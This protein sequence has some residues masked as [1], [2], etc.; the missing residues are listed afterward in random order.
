MHLFLG[1]ASI[2]VIQS[3]QRFVP[4]ILAQREVGAASAPPLVP[5]ILAQ[6]EVGTASAPRQAHKSLVAHEYQS[7]KLKLAIMH[8]FIFALNGDG[9]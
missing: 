6:R 8:E 1:I 4:N 9:T 5:H 2:S 7:S 3:F